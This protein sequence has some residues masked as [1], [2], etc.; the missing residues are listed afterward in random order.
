[1]K[2]VAK[3]ASGDILVRIHTRLYEDRQGHSE[4]YRKGLHTESKM[5]SYDWVCFCVRKQAKIQE[6]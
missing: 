3:T 5:I 2:Y 4:R 6:E 1:M